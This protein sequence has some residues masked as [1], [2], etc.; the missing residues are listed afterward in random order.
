[1]ISK[2]INDAD[3]Y[4]KFYSD[5]RIT[6][7]DAVPAEFF[8]L[9]AELANLDGSEESIKKYGIYPTNSYYFCTDSGNL[10]FYDEESKMWNII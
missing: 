5:G 8:G 2:R 3:E 10:Y 6:N 4:L 1:M 7:K 9:E